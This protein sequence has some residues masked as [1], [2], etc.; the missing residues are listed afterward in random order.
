[1]AFAIPPR[2]MQGDDHFKK[3]EIGPKKYT[4][5]KQVGNNTYTDH[6]I[7]GRS[8]K[9]TWE[10]E[11]NLSFKHYIMEKVSKANQMMGLIR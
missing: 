6:I 1:M 2:Q 8:G 9:K 7:P 4:M 3:E 5:R 11:W 10:S